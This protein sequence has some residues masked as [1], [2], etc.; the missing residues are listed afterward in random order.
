MTPALYSL[1]ILGACS[2]ISP[3]VTVGFGNFGGVVVVLWVLLPYGAILGLWRQ[4]WVRKLYWLAVTLSV[5]VFDVYAHYY[6]FFGP[7][8]AESWRIVAAPFYLFALILVGLFGN[9][10]LCGVD[11]IV[12]RKRG[13]ISSV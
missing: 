11:R 7:P 2:G 8:N 1:L 10:L 4:D 12:R 5:V 13:T 6:F 3:I 9:W